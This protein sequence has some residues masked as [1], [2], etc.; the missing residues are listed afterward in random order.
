MF[1]L[2][3]GHE[4]V[5]RMAGSQ[6]GKLFPFLFKEIMVFEKKRYVRA[7]YAP[8]INNTITK[9]IMKCSRLRNKFLNTKGETDKKT[10][11]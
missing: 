7:N 8:F 10:Y 5:Q 3:A 4:A 6:K 2:A 1:I 9:E 11:N